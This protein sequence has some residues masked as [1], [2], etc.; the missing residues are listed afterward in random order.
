[1]PNSLTQPKL[2]P[3]SLSD[4]APVAQ[5]G[6]MPFLAYANLSRMKN[7]FIVS[8]VLL[9]GATVGGSYFAYQKA[10]TAHHASEGHGE[11]D[12]KG[13]G[14]KGHDN[15][16]EKTSSSHNEMAAEAVKPIADKGEEA[17][18]AATPTPATTEPEP[19]ST[20]E[21]STPPIDEAPPVAAST[22][23]PEAG[24]ALYASCMGC[25]G[26]QGEGGVGPSLKTAATWTNEQFKQTLRAGKTPSKELQMTMPRFAEAQLSDEQVD[27][28][29]AYI[30]TLTN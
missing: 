18:E 4:L 9:L 28:L 21:P 10:T 8:I 23:N 12:N 26:T 17:T 5:T 1:M 11:H 25:H 14:E 19:A 6:Q 24:K 20:P 13:H 30:K 3:Y 16:A 7:N 2:I 15:S 29:H 22:G 27:D